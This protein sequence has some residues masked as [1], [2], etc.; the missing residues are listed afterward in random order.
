MSKRI[1]IGAV[2]V[3]VLGVVFILLRGGGVDVTIVAAAL[4]S[5]SVTIPAEG[6]T[7]A[8]ERFTVTAPVNGRITRLEL[9]EGDLVDE[10][11]LIARLFATPQ[12]PRVIATLRGERDAA[13]A[14]Y[15]QAQ[16]RLREAKLQADQAQREVERRR[17]LAEMGA[18]TPER[19]E[20]AELTATVAEER[21]EAAEADVASAR[22]TL[23]SARARLVGAEGDED[24]AIPL[25]VR[26][27]VAGRVTS[28][29]DA[30]ARVVPVGAPLLTLADVGGLE[31]VMDILSEDAVRVEPGDEIVV[32]GWG[33]DETL[34]GEVRRVTLVGYTEV[35]AL[36]VEEQRVD[37][38]GDLRHRP[39]SLGV[40]YRVSGE[41]VVWRGEDVL[42]VPTGALFRIGDSWHVFVV[43]DDRARLREVGVGHQNEDAAEI[44]EGLVEGERV[45][46]FPPAELQEGDHVRGES[47]LLE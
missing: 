23:E 22:A 34:T 33:G 27:P 43:E 14:R 8:R 20:Q 45:I 44:V 38:I 4:D 29:P 10:G 7:R 41:I 40:G 6:M 26:A 2:T 21:Q 12:D 16:T 42:T 35:S 28:V 46:L 15:R 37:V 5:M 9:E 11:R 18:I 31:I 39:S 13:E 1:V 25:D 19:M 24:D 36:G 3:G 47:V 30:S 17:P 32:T